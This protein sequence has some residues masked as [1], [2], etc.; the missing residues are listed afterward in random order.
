MKREQSSSP[1]VGKRKEG[2]TATSDTSTKPIRQQLPG[3]EKQQHKDDNKMTK[4]NSGRKCR[5][6]N[7]KITLLPQAA[8]GVR[9][10]HP[11]TTTEKFSVKKGRMEVKYTK[12]TTLN[13]PGRNKQGICKARKREREW[14]E[15]GK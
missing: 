2:G 10:P 8:A 11:R 7:P 6:I 13:K 14:T 9:A 12:A 4:K 5:S 15:H 1:E 3:P